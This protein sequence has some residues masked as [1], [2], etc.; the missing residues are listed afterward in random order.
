MDTP[1]TRILLSTVANETIATGLVGQLL[2]ERLIACGTILPGARSLYHWEGKIEQAAEALLLIK[3]TRESADRCMARIKELHPY[4]IPEI[5]LM[6]PEAVS[7][8]YADWVREA[9]ANGN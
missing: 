8:S 5:I 2:E 1:D 6:K 7:A 4:E 3:T 9:V